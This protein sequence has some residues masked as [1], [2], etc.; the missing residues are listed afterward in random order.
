MICLIQS[1]HAV[2][3][4]IRCKCDILSDIPTASL[5][6]PGLAPLHRFFDFFAGLIII[7]SGSSKQLE[8]CPLQPVAGHTVFMLQELHLA[9]RSSGRCTA[10]K[11]SI[12]F[13]FGREAIHLRFICK[14]LISFTDY[15]CIILDDIMCFIRNSEHAVPSGEIPCHLASI[16]DPIIY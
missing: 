12:I 11:V 13:L 14:I 5:V 1:N 7:R 3:V 10:V 2:S 8:D 9:D 16:N 15:K 4:V 6:R